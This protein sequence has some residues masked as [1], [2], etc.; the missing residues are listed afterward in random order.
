MWI[1]VLM[2][3]VF[4]AVMLAIG[5]YCRRH[6]TDVNGFVLG[7]RNV[8]PWL[9][10]F[11]Y[12]TSYFSAVIFVGYAGQFGWKYGIA[13]SWVG[14]GNAFLGSLLAW[15][16]LG[17]RTRI[18]TQHLGSATM[19]EFFGR[20][21]GSRALKII[22]SIIIFIFLIPYTASLY[23]GLSRLFGMAF[24]IDY[25]VCVIVMAVLT[26]IYVIAGGYMAT[27]VNDFIQG[28][29]MVFGIVAVIAAVLTSKG[30]FLAALD[31]LSRAADPA[32]SSSPGIFASFFGPDPA[33][34]LGVVILTSLGTWG[35]PQMV[36][37]FYAIKSEGAINKGMIIST[38]FAVIV[39]GGCYFLGGFGR[40]FSDRID[41]AANGFDSVVP[42]MLSG[43]PDILI[44]VVVI[45][46]LS[47]SMSTLSSLVLTSSSTL[48]LDL[49]KE[50][51]RPK[52]DQKEQLLIMRILIVVFIAVSVIL[53]IVQYKIGITFIAQM[54]GISWGAL[55]GAF[56]APFLY[57]LYWKRT[58][59]AACLVSFFFSCIVMVACVLAP[60]IFPAFLRSPINAG[61]FCML[62][63]L[64][65]VPVV[66]ILSPAP[67]KTLVDNAFS[68]YDRI[69]SVRQ[70][71]ALPDEDIVE[72]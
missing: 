9:T 57:G 16:V 54:M 67:E 71:E 4:F 51:V 36:Q 44:A 18:M 50:T 65:I 8:G 12:G 45:L 2:L 1:K 33:S 72:K 27:A 28:I 68:C 48:T 17:R 39:A 59:K 26:G 3:V 31:G 13:A 10:A 55:A 19:P 61:A 7:G 43:L 69:V 20:R 32:V 14:I 6:S 35:L 58:T 38:T 64:V 42:A 49:L 63:G 15:A 25:S 30:G 29:I 21:F 52:M 46:V 37:K 24:S 62:A 66:S 34:L 22:A 40:L 41:V 56:L 47:A 5:L 11:A 23:N 60:Q 70:R 53:A